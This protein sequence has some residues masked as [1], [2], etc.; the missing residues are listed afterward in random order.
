VN[1]Y[2]KPEIKAQRTVIYFTVTFIV[3]E[4]QLLGNVIN[5]E[6]EGLEEQKAPLWNK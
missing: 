6:K 3:L 5:H 4:E 2:F 1:P